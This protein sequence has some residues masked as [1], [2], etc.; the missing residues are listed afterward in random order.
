MS[1]TREPAKACEIGDD[2]TTCAYCGRPMW[3]QPLDE[4]HRGPLRYCPAK[5]K[6]RPVVMLP[7]LFT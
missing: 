4:G 6:V 3:M 1:R 5:S 7:Y 2:L